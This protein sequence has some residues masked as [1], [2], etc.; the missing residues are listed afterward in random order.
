MK[1]ILR[2]W[3]PAVVLLLVMSSCASVKKIP[4]FKNADEVDLAASRY[5]YDAK[6]MPKDILTIT[7]NTTDP[8]A[9]LPF[10][11]SISS[12][13]GTNNRLNTNTGQTLQTYLVDNHGDIRFPV[14]GDLHVAGLTVR[15]CEDMIREKI[16]P[17]M[18]VTEKP[19]VTVRMESFN[20]VVLGEV[21]KPGT[22]TAT[23]EKM[24]VLEA[25]AKSGD[26]TIYGRRDNIMLI[27]ED[28]YGEKTIHRFDLQDANLIT[29]PYFYLQ[30]N[31][32]IYV[33][34][35]KVKAQNS[36]VGTFTTLSISLVGTLISITN[37]IINL[38]D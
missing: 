27:R 32:V 38:T 8:Q 2:K 34:P 28:A 19:I 26:L 36:S 35:N 5:L 20:V 29:S 10:N 37:L 13:L 12:T 7:V 24:S 11:L 17:Y 23:N 22:V 18:A 9:A 15:Q 1:L 31:D 25:L 6:I 21:S 30:Q 16:V 4:Y 14:I 3:L 33:E